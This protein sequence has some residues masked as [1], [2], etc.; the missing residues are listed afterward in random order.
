MFKKINFLTSSFIEK[1]FNWLCLVSFVLLIVL[2]F[3]YYKIPFFLWLVFFISLFSC[4]FI[5]IIKKRVFLYVIGRILEALLTLF[6]VASITFV[7]LR[8]LP[9]G[10]FDQEKTLPPEI[11]A[12]IS[13]KYHLDKPL[14]WQYTHYIKGLFRGYLGESYKYTDRNIADILKDSLP[15]S[16]QLGIYALILAFLVGIP[17]GVFSAQKQDSWQDR[18]AMIFSISGI[19]LPSFV[20]APIFIL[21]FSF[22]LAWLKPALWEGTLFYILPAV[23][24]ALRPAG[25]IARLTRS[26]ILDVLSYDFVRTARA[27]GLN[28]KTIFY[29]HILKNAFLPVL[30]FSGPLIAG[31][32]TGSFIV[33]KIFAIPGLGQHF[34]NSVSNRDYPLI[35]G[36]LLVYSSLLILS[37]MIVDLLY[38]YFDPRIKV[39]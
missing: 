22:Y 31:I 24:L 33:E 36:A 30:T 20:V 37:N 9:G 17:L 39:S 4:F 25:V 34:I 27:K 5:Y 35:L 12:N 23:V 21:F 8:M 2:S 15:V 14:Y 11:Q 13:A 32:L 7:L 18:A 28:E 26:S 38:A 29:K 1:I 16:I 10:P 3:L 19:S 6:I